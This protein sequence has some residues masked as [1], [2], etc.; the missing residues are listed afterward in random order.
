MDS[1]TMAAPLRNTGVTRTSTHEWFHGR[2]RMLASNEDKYLL[3]GMLRQRIPCPILYSRGFLRYPRPGRY[4]ENVNVTFINSQNFLE[5]KAARDKMF[6]DRDVW[7]NKNINNKSS[8]FY[9]NAYHVLFNA[10]ED[11]CSTRFLPQMQIAAVGKHDYHDIS[12]NIF[13]AWGTTACSSYVIQFRRIVIIKVT[14][15]LIT[16]MERR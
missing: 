1:C 15:P 6:T 10:S 9:I 12:Q 8:Q 13:W 5:T 2:A 7:K 3:W 14:L 4:R 16:E 11:D